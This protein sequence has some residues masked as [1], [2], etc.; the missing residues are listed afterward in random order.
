LKS[1]IT[2]VVAKSAPNQA[3]TSDQ[4]PIQRQTSVQKTAAKVIRAK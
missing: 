3:P 4:P 1:R 2:A